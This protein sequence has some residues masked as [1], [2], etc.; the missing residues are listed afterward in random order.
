MELST[1]ILSGI[2]ALLLLIDSYQMVSNREPTHYCERREIKS[3]CL[4]LSSTNKTCYSVEKGW[5]CTEGWKEI[6][7]MPKE[8][9]ISERRSQG[10]LE[11][12]KPRP[13]GCEEI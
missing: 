2:V 7:I 10:R 9:E 13:I 8:I 3:N 5:R 6:P 1:K 11:S 12:C 4:R